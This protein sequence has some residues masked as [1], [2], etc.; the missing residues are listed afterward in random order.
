MKRNAA[1]G[2]ALFGVIGLIWLAGGC[3]GVAES[4]DINISEAGQEESSQQKSQELEGKLE[5]ATFGAGCYWCVEAVFQRLEGVKQVES[6]FMGGE[7]ANPSYEAVCSG[8]TGH[9]EVCQLKFDPE[10][11]TF[12]ELLEVFWKT[13]D[14]TTLNRQGADVGTQYR[15]AVFYHS[16]EQKRLAEEW[17]AKLDEAG[18]F[19]GPIVTEIS[20][21]DTF[22][23][24]KADHQNYYNNN[25]NQG[26]CRLV[27][28]PKID[29]LEKVFADKLKK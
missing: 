7:V 2:P 10:E 23:K 19:S 14:P 9:A 1:F 16:D 4:R 5:T 8:R 17:K 11:I 27:I 18:V 12:A 25:S 3:L 6:G 21:A 29:K 20:P 26:Y 13:H 24:A 22:Y 15:S 28:T